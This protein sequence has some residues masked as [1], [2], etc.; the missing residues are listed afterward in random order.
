MHLMAVAVGW[1]RFR[2]EEPAPLKPSYQREQRWRR[3]PPL[4]ETIEALRER[5]YLPAIWFIFS[6]AGCDKS[7]K[8]AH[9][10]GAG[11]TTPEEQAA[12]MDM[13]TALK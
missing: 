6:R 1:C 9:T 3:I 10:S 13:V 4:H 11:L 12:I 5:D 2:R 7:A 8:Q